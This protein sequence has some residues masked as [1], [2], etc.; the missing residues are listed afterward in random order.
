MT[1]NVSRLFHIEIVVRDADAAADFLE[2]VFG[3][4][5]VQ[6][7]FA[8]FLSG[9]FN[10]VVHV[11]LGQTVLQFIEPLVDYGLWA[12][13]LQKKGPGV[14]NLTF[15]VDD[16]EAA[17][18]A[19]EKEGAP[20]LLKFNLDWSK[21][22]PAENLKDAWPPVYMIGGEETVGFRFELGESPTKGKNRFIPE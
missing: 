10:K 9:S 8:S 17:A 18:A 16:V 6:E 4:K 19:L 2:R 14:H 7:D 3:A 5:R 12:E 11:E 1:I 22:E 13:H 20:T 21:L 15:I